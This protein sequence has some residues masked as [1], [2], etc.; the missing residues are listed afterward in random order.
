M[1]LRMQDVWLLHNFV[2]MSNSLLFSR[3]NRKMMGS[4]LL[5]IDRIYVT[6]FMG[7]LGA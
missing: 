2:R 6:G 3:S 7:K 1:K 4:N 5:R